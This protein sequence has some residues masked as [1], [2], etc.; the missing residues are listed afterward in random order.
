MSDKSFEI[1]LYSVT[2]NVVHKIMQ[3]NDWSED[4]ALE[5]FVQSKT[6][7]FLS[8]EKTKVWQ[9]SA[10]MIAQLFNEERSGELV[11]PEV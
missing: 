4:F 3:L 5:R 8:D 11:L 7:E 6:Y 10:L 1:L 2:A 9:Y